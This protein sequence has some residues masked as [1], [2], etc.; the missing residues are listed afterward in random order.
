MSL[1]SQNDNKFVVTHS[2]GLINIPALDSREIW[3][4]NLSKHTFKI[5]KNKKV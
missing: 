2:T 5:P 4:T 3:L 1:I